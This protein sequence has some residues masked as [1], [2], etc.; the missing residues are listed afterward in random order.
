MEMIRSRNKT[1]HTY[2]EEIA[3]EIFNNILGDYFHAFKAFKDKM[4]E[5]KSGEQGSLFYQ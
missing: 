1:S 5:I 4:E 2:N 3:D